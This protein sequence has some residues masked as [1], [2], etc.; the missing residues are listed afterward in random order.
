M[1]NLVSMRAVTGEEDLMLITTGGV[2]IRMDVAGISTMGRNTQGVKLI[3]MKENEDEYVATVAKVEK[4]EEEEE[5]DEA[6]EVLENGQNG[7]EEVSPEEVET[8]EDIE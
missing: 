4:E 1:V 7:A 6:A 3:S 8:N 2:L 5:V